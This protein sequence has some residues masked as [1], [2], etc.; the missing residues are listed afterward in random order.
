MCIAVPLLTL[1]MTFRMSLVH[2]SVHD[3][4]G[5]HSR[6]DKSSNKIPADH[7][8]LHSS[9]SPMRANGFFPALSLL[10]GNIL[11]LICLLNGE[12]LL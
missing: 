9:V 1:P 4:V 12:Q 7:P 11:S 5:N 10:H 6:N 8:L 2:Y 3:H